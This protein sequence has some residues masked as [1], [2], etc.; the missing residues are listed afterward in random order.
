MLETLAND[1]MARNY[2]ETTT[3]PTDTY[4]MYYN[5]L[6]IFQVGGEKWNTW[7]GTV[8]DMLVNAQ[9]RDPACFDGSWDPEGAGGHHIGATGRTLVTAYCCLS[10]EVYYR[11]LPVAAG[12]GQLSSLVWLDTTKKNPAASCRGC[13]LFILRGISEPMMSSEKADLD[14][15]EALVRRRVHATFCLA[16]GGC[17]ASIG[18]WLRH[19]GAE[20]EPHS[21]AK[22]RVSGRLGARPRPVV[23]VPR[24]RR[25][26]GPR[27]GWPGASTRPFAANGDVTR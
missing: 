23:R 16:A 6:A 1:I 24:L 7:N 20:V 18:G 3:Y 9:R 21:G 5:T 4:Y 2:P 22:R 12:G 14:E 19:L 26:I 8:R 25:G 15:R 13:F 17:F 11:Y 10:L 27:F